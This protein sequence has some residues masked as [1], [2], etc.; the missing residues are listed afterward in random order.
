MLPESD[1]FKDGRVRHIV[2]ET[3]LKI[4]DRDEFH[5]LAKVRRLKD[6]HLPTGVFRVRFARAA[7]AGYRKARSLEDP[8]QMATDLVCML[9]DLMHLSSLDSLNWGDLVAAAAKRYRGHIE[10]PAPRL[11][12][13][14]N[15]QR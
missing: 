9:S 7:V 11:G 4:H 12:L 13:M 8:K 3:L 10:E 1:R 15:H 14:R 5:G 2:W 6:T